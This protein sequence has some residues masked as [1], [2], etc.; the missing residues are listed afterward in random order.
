MLAR[1]KSV[2]GH[3]VALCCTELQSEQCAALTAVSRAGHA[4]H[5]GTVLVQNLLIGTSNGHLLGAWPFSQYEHT[6]VFF[7]LGGWAL[8]LLL[9]WLVVG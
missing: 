4:Q 2:A 6:G 9:L 8:L 7:G 5:R 1:V 3:L